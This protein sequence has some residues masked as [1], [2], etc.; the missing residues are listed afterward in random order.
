M[1][2]II[3]SSPKVENDC[4]YVSLRLTSKSL[5]PQHGVD[6]LFGKGSLG[7]VKWVFVGVRDVAGIADGGAN[8]GRDVRMVHL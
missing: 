1:I 4:Y 5:R 6:G 2:K 8:A 3:F 7:R